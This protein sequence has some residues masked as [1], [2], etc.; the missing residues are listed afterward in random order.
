MSCQENWVE[1][2]L[3]SLVLAAARP[4]CHPPHVDQEGDVEDEGE[5]HQEDGGEDPE[6]QCGQTFR[7]WWRVRENRGEHVHKNL[8]HN[9]NLWG[10]LWSW[11][12]KID[13]FLPAM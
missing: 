6:G 1:V 12:L 11:K 4:T 9:T 5:E 13:I 7:V 2:E 10:S 8:D 3:A